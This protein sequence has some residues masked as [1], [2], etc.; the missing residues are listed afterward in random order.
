MSPTEA[1]F[2]EV[3]RFIIKDHYPEFECSRLSIDVMTL[4]NDFSYPYQLK[5]SYFKPVGSPMSWPFLLEAL[6]FLC[7]LMRMMDYEAANISK[8]YTINCKD[9]E[10]AEEELRHQV[11]CAKLYREFQAAGDTN[12]VDWNQKYMEELDI[13]GTVEQLTAEIEQLDKEHE[14]LQKENME[15]PQIKAQFEAQIEKID[16]DIA[17]E[18]QDKQAFTNAIKDKKVEAER[19]NAYF[20]EQGIQLGELKENLMNQ[21]NEIK[22]LEKVIAD[23]P[24]QHEVQML[25]RLYHD[26]LDK[27]RYGELH[28]NYMTE[29]LHKCLNVKVQANQPV[30]PSLMRYG[31]H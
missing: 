24:P 1:T 20:E 3:L 19:M 25:K 12:N 27:V 13:E 17:E 11:I 9:E 16:A 26:Q 15:F 22:Q 30:L 10:E 8:L 29:P 18:D 4:M 23:Q 21:E 31:I 7:E 28:I 5:E 6:N 2:K 14:A